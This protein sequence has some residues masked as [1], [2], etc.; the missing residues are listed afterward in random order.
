MS[1]TKLQVYGGGSEITEMTNRLMQAAPG[2][3][4]LQP[5]QA[6]AV[7]QI[8]LAHDLDPWNGEV[9]YIPGSGVSV[10]IKGYRKQ[11]RRQLRREGEKGSTFWTQFERVTDPT[12]YGTD[13]ED[14]VYLCYL[15]DDVSLKAWGDSVKYFKE[16]I[17]LDE[18][19]A[20]QSAGKAPVY[21]GIGILG[22]GENSGKMPRTQRAQKRA[23]AHALKQRFDIEFAYMDDDE[24]PIEVQFTEIDQLAPSAEEAIE[25]LT[26]ET[27]EPWPSKLIQLV[28]DNAPYF[29]D[30]K[31]VIR[32]LDKSGLDRKA[33]QK[34]VKKFAKYF[35]GEID[36]DVDPKTALK[37]TKENW[38]KESAK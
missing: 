25:V 4:N 31:M 24:N 14:M 20:I 16:E 9:W 37:N 15:R 17:G 1:N 29:P 2:S 35:Q 12:Q 36:Q 6:Q 7:A 32:L 30:E 38:N 34:S 5:G 3:R 23:E 11:S 33:T 19:I 27:K 10:G 22:K 26:G 13:K 28:L 8:A 21:I 18:K